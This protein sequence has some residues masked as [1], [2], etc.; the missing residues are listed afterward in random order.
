MN[1]EEFVAKLEGARQSGAGWVARC[2]AHGDANPSLSVNRG[3]DGRI[4]VHCHAG[5]SAQEVVEA[6][7]L[8]LADLMPSNEKAARTIKGRW[9]EWVCDYVY[10]DENGVALYKSSRYVKKS[11]GKKTFVMKHPDKSKKFGWGFGLSAAGITRVPFR[12]P[13]ILNA[14]KQGKGIV[15]CE[16]EKDVL[17]IERKIGCCATCNVG[18]ALKWGYAFPEDWGKWFKGI[19][20]IIIIADNDPA[21]IKKTV[22]GKEVT[23]D[24][25]VGQKHA[26]DVK[27]RLEAAGYSG[28]IR[29]MTMPQVEGQ[30]HVKDFT[31]WMEAREAAGLKADRAAFV[32]AVQGSSWPEE[33][34]WDEAAIMNTDV[35][36]AK[37][38]GGDTASDSTVE[39]EAADG[40]ENIGRFGALLRSSDRSARTYKVDFRIGG[41]FT[42][43][44]KLNWREIWNEKERKDARGHEFVDA[45]WEKTTLPMM[46]FLARRM[47]ERKMG[48]EAKLPTRLQSELQSIVCLLWLRSRGKFFWDD[49]AKGFQTSLYFDEVTGVLM[50]IRSDE[51]QSFIATESEINREAT[52]FK[53][54]MS[55]IDDAAIS[56][57]VSAGVIPSNSWDRRDDAVY[58]SSGDAEMY[59]LK[60]GKV[61]LVQNGTDGVVFMRGKTLMPWKLMDGDGVDPFEDAIVFK[62]A[63]WGEKCAKMN[64]RL[65]VLNLFCCHIMKPM[66]LIYGPA[67]SGKTQLAKSIKEV[68]GV[69]ID[70]NLDMSVQQLKDGDKGEEAFWVTINEGKL[71]VF[72]NVDGSPSKWVSNALQTAST[73]GQYKVRTLYTTAGLTVMRANATMILTANDPKYITEGKGG[74]SDRTI[75]IP[76][77]E[78][79]RETENT[80]LSRNIKERRDQYMTWIVRTV[81]NA[82]A[83]DSP[84]DK[85]INRRHPDYGKFSVK[86]G[87]AFGK[88]QEVIEALSSAEI[89][90]AILPLRNNKITEA[91]LGLLEANKWVMKLQSKPASDAIIEMMGDSADEDT[92]RIYSSRRIGIAIANNLKQFRQL[93]KI[94]GPKKIE[95]DTTWE[96]NGLTDAGKVVLS[97]GLG[98]FNTRFCQKSIE[99]ENICTLAGNALTNPPNPPIR[100]RADSHPSLREEEESIDKWSFEL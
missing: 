21:E 97:G 64:A 50:R 86:C 19:P 27:R 76:L 18:G 85:S 68:L 58:V 34:N 62:S 14:A 52:G 84:V 67:G 29:L 28:N 56:S 61:E 78:S 37:E 10:E 22:R 53:Y 54:L 20:G 55:L 91:I 32:E 17:N 89:D 95:G 65:F 94:D 74:M 24:F 35:A 60:G 90:K 71:E 7:G 93:F 48:K 75:S 2:P 79:E 8:K 69:R 83:D 59:R 51:F 9:G 39:T 49:A 41:A 15:I 33:W 46:Q 100:A 44:L 13:R 16:G 11:D 88:E 72:D 40:G 30:K 82:F 87:R 23:K 6:M 77:V 36:A 1:I 99:S 73:D 43:E 38:S 25:H 96:V 12:L 3:E 81:A 57:V 4:L 98:G 63:S 45:D 92:A 5:C 42:V 80:I 31:D 26:I 70:G 47:V 66:L